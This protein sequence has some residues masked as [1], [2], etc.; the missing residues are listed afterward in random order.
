MSQP[1]IRGHQTGGGGERE[2]RK[3]ERKGRE[4][5]KGGGGGEE[6]EE[7]R[8]VGSQSHHTHGA[9]SHLRCASPIP[10]TPADATRTTGENR[11]SL[12]QVPDPVHREQSEMAG[13]SP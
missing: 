6:E 10:A 3:R 8:G 2:E 7:G 13:L 1:W 4:R 5:G 9:R 11:L 12:P